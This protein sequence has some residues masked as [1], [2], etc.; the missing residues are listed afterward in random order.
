MNNKC[1]VCTHPNSGDINSMLLEGASGA[2]IG[3][4]FQLSSSSINNHKRNHLNRALAIESK[5]HEISDSDWID[6]RDNY[7]RGPIDK[8]IAN[9][10]LGIRKRIDMVFRNLV[11]KGELGEAIKALR[12][13]RRTVETITK[14]MHLFESK[15]DKH[16]WSRVISSILMVL[17]DYPE[18]KQKV[19][20]VLEREK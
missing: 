5:A 12:E 8:G 9:D 17:E 1:S 10:L 19:A 2:S 3:R 6:M 7:A 13:A 16:D 20:D 15:K 18:V 11:S 4:Q 14:T